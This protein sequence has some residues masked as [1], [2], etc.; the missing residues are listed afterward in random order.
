MLALALYRDGL[1]PNCGRPMRE[2]TAAA[3]DGKFE[4]DVPVRCHATTALVI[5]Q[6]AFTNPQP[7]AML[8]RTIRR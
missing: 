3:A 7:E 1:C 5:A 8:W 6:K 4:A 2:C